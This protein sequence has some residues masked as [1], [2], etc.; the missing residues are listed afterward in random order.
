MSDDLSHLRAAC[1]AIVKGGGTIF[2]W[3]WDDRFHAAL[4]AFPSS[5]SPGARALLER[6]FAQRWNHESILGAPPDALGVATSLGGLR[7]GQELFL[8]DPAR[9]VTMCACWWPWGSGDT[10][11]VRIMPLTGDVSESAEEEV[12]GEFRRWFGL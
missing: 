3:E 12:L 5:A 10:I 1:E 7:A 4:S 9:P 6:H 11:S 8:S 2:R